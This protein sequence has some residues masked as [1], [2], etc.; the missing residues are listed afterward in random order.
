MGGDD[1]RLVLVERGGPAK[2]LPGRC[3]RGD[4]LHGM[5]AASTL[6]TIVVPESSAARSI[7]E[8]RPHCARRCRPRRAA[9][10]TRTVSLP[11]ASSRS[12]LKALAVDRH[13]AGRCRVLVH[14]DVGLVAGPGDRWPRSRTIGPSDIPSALVRYP[15][16]AHR[17][18]PYLPLRSAASGC[19]GR[20]SSRPGPGS[21]PSV[22]PRQVRGGCRPGSTQTADRPVSAVAGRERAMVRPALGPAAGPGTAA[23]VDEG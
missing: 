15:V 8:S 17:A 11:A 13:A 4:A 5:T 23:V 6:T 1:V 3:R 20:R 10:A 14:R 7:P 16:A 9:S 21:L 18:Q 12:C 22:C 19:S 2:Y